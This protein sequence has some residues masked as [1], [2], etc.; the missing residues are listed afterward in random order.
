M[1]RWLIAVLSFAGLLALYFGY[2]T[3]VR[4]PLELRD[5]ERRSN[6]DLPHASEILPP[7]RLKIGGTDIQIP[8]GGTASVRVFDP[9]T[10]EATRQFK[11]EEF[12]PVADAQNEIWVKR[13]EVTLRMPSGVIATITA[14]QGQVAVERIETSRAGWKFGWLQGGTRIV[15]DRPADPSGGDSRP[16]RLI[17]I[18]MDRMDFDMEL[19]R[20]KSEGD[21]RA[22]GDEFEIEGAGLDFAWNVAANRVEELRIARGKRLAL[23]KTSGLLDLAGQRPAAASQPASAAPATAPLRRERAPRRETTYTCTLE[24]EVTARQHGVDGTILSTLEAGGLKLLFDLGRGGD[25]MARRSTSRP[26]G[27][28]RIEVLWDGP[29][30]LTPQAPPPISR[31]ST[32]GGPAAP[33]EARRRLEALGPVVTLTRGESRLRCGRIEFYDDTGQV[34]LYPGEDDRVTINAGPRKLVTADSIYID[35]AGDV[36]KLV[37]AV[38]LESRSPPS[39]HAGNSR[40]RVNSI[41]CSQIAELAL[42]PGSGGGEPAGG[43]P[44]DFSTALRSGA[45]RG[46]VEV[47]LADQ[48]LSA[49]RLD[50]AFRRQAAPAERHGAD[51]ASGGGDASFDMQIE[52]ATAVGGVELH[53]G[54]DRVECGRLDLA[55]AASETGESYPSSFDASGSVRITRRASRV[56]GDRVSGELA[57]L[58]AAPPDPAATGPAPAAPTDRGPRLAIRTV[59]VEG[60][61]ELVDRERKVG[62]RGTRIRAWVSAENQ[63]ER[64][65]VYGGAGGLGLVHASPYTVW[66]ERIDIDA[67]RRTLDVDGPSR[68]AFTARRGLTGQERDRPTLVRVSG[69]RSLRIDSEGNTIRID[70]DVVARSGG[71]R[72]HGS[73]MTLRLEDAPP[74][75]GKQPVRTSLGDLYAS[76]RRLWKPE[77]TESSAN[78]VPGAGFEGQ[79]GT[80]KEPV[81]LIV[82][83]AYAQTRTFEPGIRDPVV[84]WS[85]D[86]PWMEIDIPRRLV[87][88]S[89]ATTL[90]LTDYRVGREAG[91]APGPG[92][93]PSDLMSGGPSQTLIT[94]DTAFAYQLGAEGP[95]RQDSAL[96]EGRVFM[97]Y[98]AGRDIVNLEQ[99]PVGQR[100]DRAALEKLR[101]R[102]STLQCNR[103]EV[104][105]G[106]PDGD[107]RLEP[108][109]LG[110]PATRLLWMDAST[111]VFLRDR[112]GTAVTEVNADRLRFDR[113]NGLVSVWGSRT[114][115]ARIH[116]FDETQGKFSTP[117]V[118]RELQLDVVRNSIRTKDRVAGEVQP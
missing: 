36:I 65:E 27:D 102:H 100:Y 7:E 25:L 54:E 95:A 103:M 75:A 64:A 14:E 20:M 11:Y 105:F 1:R 78:I 92:V 63:L 104:A 110:G 55:F 57:R 80:R 52:S 109:A 76:L 116:R 107:G 61:A 68:I 117:V 82:E 62:A 13:P 89:G 67:L 44:L 87:Q 86:A 5:D 35:R 21:V 9:N 33:R 74:P 12:K 114:A 97:V 18:T 50:V 47:R 51:R 73:A 39:E 91:G 46:D 23:L 28:E 45:F 88:T 113:P 99:T 83:N 66:A 8:A 16:E 112:Q 22:A 56:R 48:R 37:G 77:A 96:L 40:E 34:W 42:H 84:D 29:L 90:L 72:L 24:G 98:R 81:R 32:A 2:A 4:D 10:G 101:S 85:L 115:D 41:A 93:V 70:G 30:T 53:S 69:R 43:D 106:R 118:G 94:C 59:D 6:D 60:R 19:G 15:I 71:E 49:Q 17:E 79:R 26:S 38:R 111:D 3:V 108:G 58:P 31:A